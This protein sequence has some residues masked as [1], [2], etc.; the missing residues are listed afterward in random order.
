MNEAR[1]YRAMKD[2]VSGQVLIL[3]STNGTTESLH[4][5]ANVTSEGEALR[6]VALLSPGERTEGK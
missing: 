4:I 1:S 2:L 3:Y 5:L 6:L